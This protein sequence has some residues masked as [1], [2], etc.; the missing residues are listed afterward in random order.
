MLSC[1]RAL[2]F[3][4]FLGGEAKT[5][6]LMIEGGERGWE[7]V[8]AQELVKDER[9]GDVNPSA[10]RSHPQLDRRVSRAHPQP[11]QMTH[12]NALIFPHSDYHSST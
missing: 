5:A 12:M 7:C 3:S 10:T 8:V 4:F 2:F 6:Y 9:R 11:T 1:S